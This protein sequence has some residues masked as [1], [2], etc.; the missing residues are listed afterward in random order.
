MADSNQV[1]INELARELEI[2][3]KVLIEYLP[4]IGVTEKK[5]HSSSIDNSHAELARKHFL[6]LAAQEAAAEA[7]KVKAA[8]A[9]SKPSRPAAPA[10]PAAQ[11]TAPVAAATAPAARPATGPAGPAQ[12]RPT[13]S[14][15][16]PATAPAATHPIP[17]TTPAA[18]K[19]GVVPAG[20]APAPSH[21]A[22]PG[23]APAAGSQAATPPRPVAAGTTPAQGSAPSHRPAAPGGYRPTGAPPSGQ[24][25]PASSG[26]PSGA[27]QGRPSQGFRPAAPGQ[28]R[29]GSAPGQ[30]RPGAPRPGGGAP[31]RFPQRPGSGGGRPGQEPVGGQRPGAGI[32]KAEP[33]KPLY[34]RKPPARGRPLIEKRYAEG[35]RKLHPVRPRAGA[36]PGRATQIEQV[37]PVKREPRAVTVTEGITVRELAEKLDIRAKELLKTLLD[38]GVFAS[39]N[40]AL[41]VPTATNLAE[42][43]NGIVQVVTFE[44]Q[45]VQ[46]EKIKEERTGNE[47]PRAPVVTVMGHVDHG[48]TSLLDVI[49]QADVAG[50]EAGGITQHIG[51]YEAH[52]QGKRIVFIDTPGHEAFTRMRARGAKVTDIVVLVVGADDGIMPQT[53]E[54]I[55]HARA[56]GVPIVVAI[57]K[58][59]KPDAQPERVKRQLSDKGLMPEE[60]GGDTVMVEVSAKM[61]TNI[62]K[63]LE[64]ILLVGDLRELK[65]DPDVP[66]SG[67]V[68]E[69]R[70]DK[71]RGPVATMLV[72]NGTLHVGDVF[73]V[74]AVYGKVRAMFDDRGVAIKQAGPSTPV[75][76]L[77]LQSVPEA[78]DQFQVADEA[79]ARHIVEYRQGKQREASLAKSASGRLTLDQLHEQLKVGEVKELPVV[80]KADVQ[81]SVEVLNEM[82]PKLSNDQVKLKVIHA[83]VGAVNESDVLLASTSGAVIVAFNVRPERKASDLAQREGVD[84]RPYTIIYELQDEL[85]KAMS[86]LLAP[87]IK[88]TYLGRAEVR[89]TFKVKGVGTIAGC[90][91]QDGIMKRDAEVRVQ[92]DNVVIYTGRITSLKRFKEDT[93]EVR[94]GFECGVGVSN[95]SDVKVGDILECFKMEKTIALEMPPPSER[96]RRQERAGRQ[97]SA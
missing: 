8:A 1:R 24:R 75:E 93:N 16:A 74:G 22:K 86:G 47:V 94:Q 19:P 38:R 25:Y 3:A 96:P 14:A 23:V 28:A 32:P 33:G 79:K 20:S 80:V 66:A 63:L 41:D 31:S 43:F 15:A 95:F 51:A 62:P 55:S 37:A 4:E 61:K 50:G 40:Q 53:E 45:V 90:S 76:V 13:G 44:E 49:R 54:A 91:V 12:A 46:E 26:A 88:E 65:A 48:K 2:K 59:D 21:V 97:E 71:G 5:T 42:A 83:S 81:G 11:R 18:A 35:E 9:K 30:G 68:L 34:A 58:I 52:V 77:G 57:N 6:G 56:A 10:Q 29:P 73:I 82:L 72:Q 17:K 84:I 69:S 39:I 60:W 7:E 78:G 70:V 67:T 64:M 85:K 87:V 92:R 89:N 36:G 27:A